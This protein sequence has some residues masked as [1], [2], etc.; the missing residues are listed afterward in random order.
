[1]AA[2][3]PTKN[4]FDLADALIATEEVLPGGPPRDG[5]P[6]IDHPRFDSA[7]ATN[8]LRGENRVLGVVRNGVKKAYPISIMNWHEIVNDRFGNEAVAITYCPL[9]GTGMAFLAQTAGSPLS[10]GVSGLLYNSDMLLYDR[11]TQSL[12]SQITAQAISGKHKGHRLAAIPVTHTTWSDWRQRHPDTLVLSQDTGFSRDYHR[13]PYAGYETSRELFFTVKFR[14]QGYH[15]KER[16]L[17][18]E[19]DGRHKAYP[20][21][22]LSKTTGTVRDRV[23]GKDIE[24]RYD[25]QHQTA[26]AVD[27]T[28]REL[29]TVI[30]YWFAWYG[31]HPETG[32]YI[33]E[34]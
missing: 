5:I 17:G 2:A 11:Q 13:S 24:I 34:E 19:V 22:E 23:A 25:A 14:A 28:G 26:A 6:A 9:C 16:I 8:F 7:A 21:A 15:P 3:A 31:F 33:H 20:F 4:G 29:V 30:A 12:W 18:L 32:I 10:F 1:M 27:E